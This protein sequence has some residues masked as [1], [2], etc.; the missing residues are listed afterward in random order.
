MTFINEQLGRILLGVAAVLTLLL[1]S[2]NSALTLAAIPETDLNR[3]VLVELD[4]NA[5][6]T[7]SP[8]KYFAAGTAADAA[9]V[10]RCIFV[11]EKKIT[12]FEPVDLEVPTA[13]VMAPPQLLPEPGPA[14]EGTDKLPRFGD[15]FPAMTVD[16]PDPNKP[17]PNKADPNKADPNKPKN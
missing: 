4:K 12:P 5:L 17:D 10:A 2:Q 8:E 11:A 15:E 1:W 9:G 16:K 14:L 7:A 13:A 6:P 3:K